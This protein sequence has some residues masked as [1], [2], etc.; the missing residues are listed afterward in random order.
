[1]QKTI[2]EL[3]SHALETIRIEAESIVNHGSLITDYIA[4][5]VE[6]FINSSQDNIIQLLVSR[7]L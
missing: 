6:K 4:L 2:R 3:L 7:Y 5:R 1:M